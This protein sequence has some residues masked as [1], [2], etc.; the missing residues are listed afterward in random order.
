MVGSFRS[1]GA[2]MAFFLPPRCSFQVPGVLGIKVDGA[3]E[4]SW[5]GRFTV[6]LYMVAKPSLEGGR[7]GLASLPSTLAY[8]LLL[9]DL[10]TRPSAR[11]HLVL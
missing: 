5:R 3:R 6:W 8:G 7:C 1:I 11:C 9:P 2:S 4:D 10:G